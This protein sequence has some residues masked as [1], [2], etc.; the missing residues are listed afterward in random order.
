MMETES[1]SD[2]P[3]SIAPQDL[4]SVRSLLQCELSVRREGKKTQNMLHFSS[5]K[6]H[7][8]HSRRLVASTRSG[9]SY[10]A[11]FSS[12]SSVVYILE[13]RDARLSER[14]PQRTR[15]V[16]DPPHAATMSALARGAHRARI[17]YSSSGECPTREYRAEEHRRAH[18]V[19]LLGGGLSTGEC[20][21]GQHDAMHFASGQVV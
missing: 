14:A 3:C 12:N 13:R 10:H 4:S 6:M 18:P 5:Q 20:P 1:T 11:V 19:L 9:H 17:C 16:S 2:L 7:L 15:A 8:P 21:R